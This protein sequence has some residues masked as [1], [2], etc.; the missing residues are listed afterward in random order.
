MGLLILDDYPLSV[1]RQCLLILVTILHISQS[2]ISVRQIKKRRKR[3][4][5]IFLSYPNPLIGVTVTS[6]NKVKIGPEVKSGFLFLLLS[7]ATLCTVYNQCNFLFR[8]QWKRGVADNRERLCIQGEQT[9][10]AII[11]VV[12]IKVIR[13]STCN[14]DRYVLICTISNAWRHHQRQKKV[15]SDSVFFSFGWGETESTWYA[16][17]YLAYCTRPEWWIMSEQQSVQWLGETPKYSEKT[18]PSAT[19]LGSNLGRLGGTPAT[20][21][22][23]NGSALLQLRWHSWLV[24]GRHSGMLIVFLSPS[25]KL[26]YCLNYSITAH[27]TQASQSVGSSLVT[28]ASVL[29]FT[30]SF[31]PNGNL[32]S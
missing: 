27:N 15:A 31:L 5:T 17:H 1:I 23:S 30:T 32:D 29:T 6:F 25:T 18:C 10:G 28:S 9:S 8:C 7:T 2:F 4:R 19:E 16:G 11:V 13:H 12:I 26:W 3:G 24:C 14:W 21:R 20:N 22:L